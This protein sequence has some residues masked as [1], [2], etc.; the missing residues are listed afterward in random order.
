MILP[1]EVKPE[2]SLYVIGAKVLKILDDYHLGI[3][4]VH[5][6]FEMFRNENKGVSFNYFM[7]ALDWLFII[8]AIKLKETKIQKCF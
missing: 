6:L 4:D 2:K 3:I 8:D 1:R 7:Y 5:L